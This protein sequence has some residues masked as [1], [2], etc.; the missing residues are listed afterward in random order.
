MCGIAGYYLLNGMVST[1]AEAL[2]TMARSI[3]HRGPDD[4]GFTLINTNTNK[5]INCSGSESDRR[6]QEKLPDIKRHGNGFQ[7]DI[8]LAQRRYS[9]IDLSPAG[10]QPMWS[11]DGSVCLIF[12]GEIYNYVELRKELESIGYRFN[13][14]S[15]TEVLITAYTEWG[16]EVFK[17]LNGPW[18]IALY[19]RRKK[20]LLLSRDRIGKVPLYYAISNG[21]LYWASEIKAILEAAGQ[22]SFKVRNQAVDDYIIHGWRDIDGTF[23]EGINDFPVASYAWVE[24]DLS[25]KIEPYWSLPVS[26]LTTGEISVRD[27]SRKLSELLLDSIRIRQRADV[28]V[29]FELSG[30]MDS[31][32]LVSMAASNFSE[33][34]T[35]YTI[36]FEEE[37]SNEEPFARAVADMYRDKVNY[38]VLKPG[39]DDFWMDADRF[40]WVE[41]EPFH[42][43]NLHTNQFQ[44]RTIKESG[45]KVVIT[46]SAGD[47]VLAGYPSEYYLPFLRYLLK[48]RKV[49]ELFHE[50]QSSSE[51]ST[52]R[53]VARLLKTAVVGGMETALT[54]QRIE[55]YI[56]DI[57]IKPRDIIFRDGKRTDFS[58]RMLDNMTRYQMNYWLRSGN[59]STLGIPI[60]PRAPF[61]DYRI[62]DFAFSLPPEYLIHDGWHKWILRESTKDILPQQVVWR[63]QKMGFPFPWREWLI[64]SK[65]IVALNL[66]ESKCT[67]L[68]VKNLMKSYDSLVQSN[69]QL[70]WRLICLGLWWRRV[71]ERKGLVIG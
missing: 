13:T 38:N 56:A 26:R 11:T 70:L 53:T 67:Y 48:N 54:G 16:T 33:K 30:G 49:S 12:N 40:I 10:H 46:G 64:H 15:D 44:R 29:A 19:D 28:P 69:P 25:L 32:A 17:H 52:M 35:T 47:E 18:A 23:W 39:K 31:S 21:K 61:L 65:S 42:S 37:H 34:V 2:F 6:I 43:P 24:P 36:E 27:A 14:S 4:E 50:T 59:K 9:I 58:G 22:N 1:D 45:T 5:E 60:E 55:K 7:H 63:R 62:V 71:I 41:E 57:Y 66:H 20:K 8:A 51:Y 3:R 68:D